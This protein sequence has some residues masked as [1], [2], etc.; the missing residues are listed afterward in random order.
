M[1]KEKKVINILITF[2]ISHKNGIKIF[3][4]YIVNHYP[5]GTH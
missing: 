2:S 5:K 1:G 3:L 4:K